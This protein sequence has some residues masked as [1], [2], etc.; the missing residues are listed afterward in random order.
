M[1]DYDEE[2][3]FKVIFHLRGSV[4]VRASFFSVPAA[5]ISVVL[6]VLNDEVEGF[7]K[8][9]GIVSISGSQTWAAATGVL[10]ILLG[11]RTRQ[12]LSRFWEGTGLLHQMRGEWFD[13]VSCCFTFS[14]GGIKA[15]RCEVEVFRQTIV[16][17]MSL[18]HGSALEEIADTE[19]LVAID[20]WGLDLSTLQLLAQCKKV[21]GFNRVELILHLVQTLITKALDDQVVKIPPPIISRVYQTLSRGFV[22]LLNAKK[23]TD[24]RFPLPYAQLIGMLLLFHMVSTPFL[25]AVIIDSKLFAAIFTFVPVF[26]GFSLNFVASELENPFGNDD[27]DLPLIHFQS[28][29]NSSLLMLLHKN[30]DHVPSCTSMRLDSREMKE[31]ATATK[32]RRWSITSLNDFGD[33]IESE[34]DGGSNSRISSPDQTSPGEPATPVPRSPIPLHVEEIIP[35]LEALAIRAEELSLALPLL[36]RTARSQVM[37][38]GRSFEAIRR[39]S[40]CVTASELAKQEEAEEEEEEEQAAEAK[41]Q[42]APSNIETTGAPNP[43]TMSV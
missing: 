8:E 11:F 16:R 40:E 18:C 24:T 36:S 25:I 22:N 27:N 31:S 43:N 30:T 37:E 20:V 39:L 6:L 7:W 13:S 15:K 41:T 10:T 29:M 34:C 4:A 35:R 42:A 32:G 5:L 21:H 2:W 38:I 26:G 9:S 23:I 1:I 14:R 19:H 17:L 33:H 3:L 12:A 28:E